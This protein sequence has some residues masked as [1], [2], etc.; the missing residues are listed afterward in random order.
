MTR[1]FPTEVLRSVLNNLDGSKAHQMTL[2]KPFLL[3]AVSLFLLLVFFITPIATI[4]VLS[5]YEHVAGYRLYEPIPTLENYAQL[6]QSPFFQDAIITT[7]LLG[8]GSAIGTLLLGYPAAYLIVRTKSVILRNILLSTTISTF[9]LS[10]VVRTYAFFLIMGQA[11]IV[12]QFLS[13]L[14]FEPVSL[15]GSSL[16]VLIGL[17]NLNTPFT[18]LILIAPLN[19]LDRRIEEAARTLGAT[20][21]QSFTKV[22]LPLSVHAIV[23]AFSISFTL[24]V[25]A[26]VVPAIIGGG[27]TQMVT[28]IIYSKFLE[29]LNWPEGSMLA[30]VLLTISIIIFVTTGRSGQRVLV[31]QGR[32]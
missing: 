28:N 15:L 7:I 20:R 24:G 26:F 23:A 10:V 11:G 1:T 22:T 8:V 14:G 3:I 12:N 16:S 25:T 31:M 17:V 30:M 4:G 29:T 9:M 6:L 5:F 13:F 21:L 27:R 2:A 32:K 19:N 18:I